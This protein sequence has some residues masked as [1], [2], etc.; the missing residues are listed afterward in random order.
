M[1]ITERLLMGLTGETEIP[2]ANKSIYMDDLFSLAKG[3]ADKCLYLVRFQ[4]IEDAK[5]CEKLAQRKDAAQ[6]ERRADVARYAGYI[7]DG[8]DYMRWYAVGIAVSAEDYKGELLLGKGELK[9]VVEW[10]AE[11]ERRIG[12]Q[13]AY[14]GEYRNDKNVPLLGDVLDGTK[15]ADGAIVSTSF[16]RECN[17]FKND[18]NGLI[19]KRELELK[20]DEK[21]WS[22]MRR[23]WESYG[24]TFIDSS[25]LAAGYAGKALST[26]G[27]G[28]ALDLA[29]SGYFLFRGGQ[30]IYNEEYAAGFLMV[31]AIGGSMAARY[32]KMA[33]IAGPAALISNV[34]GMLITP[35]LITGVMGTAY[36]MSRY[37][38]THQQMGALMTNLVFVGAIAVHR[39]AKEVGARGV[40]VTATKDG[41]GLAVKEVRV[42][43][44]RSERSVSEFRK[45]PEGDYQFHSKEVDV[46]YKSPLLDRTITE[47]WQFIYGGVEPGRLPVPPGILPARF[48]D[49]VPGKIVRIGDAYARR[50]VEIGPRRELGK[51]REIVELPIAVNDSR[52]RGQDET[53]GKGGG[54][55]GGETPII[56]IIK[57][58]ETAPGTTTKQGG[59][60]EK[61]GGETPKVAETAGEVMKGAETKTE[62]GKGNK[63]GEAKDKAAAEELLY[64]LKARKEAGLFQRIIPWSKLN[65]GIA[66]RIIKVPGALREVGKEKQKREEVLLEA[67]PEVKGE[68]RPQ[69]LRK[70]VERITEAVVET[71]RNP[72]RKEF[73]REAL[74]SRRIYD[75][76]GSDPAFAEFAE[77]TGI[78]PKVLN[79]VCRRPAFW[80]P[81]VRIDITEKG[82]R[83]KAEKEAVT[84]KPVPEWISAPARALPGAAAMI[85]TL[86]LADYA[87]YRARSGGTLGFEEFRNRSVPGSNGE[88][89]S[90]VP[91]YWAFRTGLA[92]LVSWGFVAPLF[93]NMQTRFV[94][95]RVEARK[96]VMLDNPAAV[97]AIAETKAFKYSTPEVQAEILSKWVG[98]VL[99]FGPEWGRK[100]IAKLGTETARIN[101]PKWRYAGGVVTK[102]IVHRTYYGKFLGIPTHGTAAAMV[103]KNLLATTFGSGYF[104]IVRGVKA[105]KNRGRFEFAREKEGEIAEKR[106][107]KEQEV[108]ERYGGRELKRAESKEVEKEAY[109]MFK[110]MYEE[111][112]EEKKSRKEAKKEAKRNN[113]DF[114]KTDLAE[115]PKAVKVQRK[116]EETPV[117]G[118]QMEEPFMVRVGGMRQFGMKGDWLLQIGNMKRIVHADAF[119]REGYSIV[120]REGYS[121]VPPEA[122]SK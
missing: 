12:Y 53:G 23:V 46:T 3:E 28:K 90:D 15:S 121:I 78:D 57:V 79:A 80:M 10:N 20:A 25:M 59:K 98:G 83:I 95:K 43:G 91:G 65:L 73:W 88:W 7:C 94:E 68:E 102:E 72:L 82:L 52:V 41:R 45:T 92:P 37:V 74:T 84:L 103:T 100:Y 14:I 76:V 85:G 44:S 108:Q 6:L 67:A 62:G 49:V 13:R 64:L 18:M 117:L 27:W 5:A 2:L 32:S 107:E 33:E 51:E 69:P 110:K 122:L 106:Y 31:A 99:I 38:F 96:N 35:G 56:P 58:G 8:M 86:F 93:A 112:R 9:K 81:T 104:G 30:A 4:T 11:L 111:Y 19:Q 101:P 114:T 61:A 21:G 50:G 55:S 71:P 89:V 75:Q 29:S 118:M 115:E 119:K 87:L 39:P 113:S 36:D 120:K 77:K 97:D 42:E 40:E 63:A 1:K 60:K 70:L 24:M 34:S 26:T 66:K 16:T 17:K 48:G 105:W 54:K 109:E 22:Q 47:S 116:G